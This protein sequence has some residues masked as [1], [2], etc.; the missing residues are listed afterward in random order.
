[1]HDAVVARP[2]VRFM[3]VE[4]LVSCARTS[5]A[6]SQPECKSHE[7]TKKYTHDTERENNFAPHAVPI[8]HLRQCYPPNRIP[9]SLD[10]SETPKF[11]PTAAKRFFLLL[12]LEAPL[13]GA[14]VR[15]EEGKEKERPLEHGRGK[16]E[17]GE[18]STKEEEE[19]EG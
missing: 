12:S 1:M 7:A 14:R 10:R 19:E 6:R 11:S 18:E 2:N 13:L 17:V 4:T 3:Y 5:K 8:A 15:S 9:L 16:E